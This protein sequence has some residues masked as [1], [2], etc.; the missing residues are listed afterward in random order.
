MRKI[1]LLKLF[2]LFPFLTCHAQKEL[3]GVNTGEEYG[4]GYFGNITKYDI[5]GENAVIIH[6]FDS[7]QGYRP[8][9]K[10]FLA[11]NGK[12]YGTT[13]S[14]GNSVVEGSAAT[15]GVLFEYDPVLDKYRVVH[16]FQ[17]GDVN[18]NP[19]TPYIGVIEPIQGKLYGATQNIMYQYDI[20]TETTTFYNRLP[21]NLLTITSEFIKANDG[22]LYSTAGYGFCINGT[23]PLWNG[24]IIKFD[25]TTNTLSVVHEQD[26]NASLEGNYPSGLVE[27]SPGI[28]NGLTL[29]G[30]IHT[31]QF[32]EPYNAAGVLFEYN[33]STNTYTK[34]VDFDGLTIGGTPTSLINGGNGML[35]GVCQEGGRAPG[36][37]NTNPT[38]FRGTLY[39]YATTTGTIQVKQYFSAGS[40][41]IVR[42][43]SSLLK[44]SNGQFMGTMPNAALFRW[45]DDTNS[46]SIPILTGDLTNAINNSNL[47]EIC[48]KPSYQEISVNTFDACAG[49]NFTYNIQ[50]TNATSYQW[51]KDGAAVA[52]QNSGILSLNNVTVGDAGNYTCFMSNECGAT[53]TMPIALSVNC[54]GVNQQTTLKHNITMYPN[55]AESDLMIGLP[56]NID[57]TINKMKII[58]LLGQT[59]LMDNQK[60]ISSSNLS[61][62]V[63][64]LIKGTYIIM[65]QSNFGDWNGRFVKD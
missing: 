61:I 21:L 45:N 56:K 41:N 2:L 6:E 50:N 65:I 33:I 58:N 42:Y 51:M 62:D 24:C 4:Q 52:G 11:S 27:S 49:E 23:T 3:W 48:R 54:L 43:P 63:S 57:V 18:Y 5:N 25:M 15:A 20:A 28:L 17:I 19:A 30:G 36:N 34:K 1:T 12:L 64:S 35:Y 9:G 37:P 46:I 14:G 22:N 7:I 13:L 39:E 55:P 47:I 16:D 29:Y 32:G 38:Y 44:T 59:V 53:L 26:C 31:Y 60:K 8:K 10:L 40:G